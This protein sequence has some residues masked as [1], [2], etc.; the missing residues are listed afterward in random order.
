MRSS[1]STTTT[2][3]WVLDL[4]PEFRFRPSDEK[5]VNLLWKKIN[6]KDYQVMP[7]INYKPWDLPDNESIL[8]FLRFLKQLRQ[9]KASIIP[10]IDFYKHEP[11]DLAGAGLM[12]PDSPYQAR[13]WFCFSRPDYKYVDSPRR[14]RLTE[15]G[16]WKITGQPR[17]VKS[18]QLS[19]SLTCKKK[20]LTFHLGRPKKSSNTGWVKQEYYLTPTDPGSNP[21]QLSG[22][23]LYRV[24][25][26]SADY[27]SDNKKRQDVSICNESLANPAIGGYMASNSQDYHF[28][29]EAEEHVLGTGNLNDGEPGGFVSSDFDDMIQEQ[30]HLDSPSPPP[31]LPRPHQLPQLGNVHGSTGDYIASISDNQVAAIHHMIT[32]EEELLAFKELER[33]LLG[34][35]NPDDGEPGSCVSD[36]LQELCAP[37]G[38]D[39]D[40]PVPPPGPPELGNAPDVYSDECSSWPSQIEDNDSSLPNKNNIPTNYDSKPVSNTASNFENQ[41]KDERIPEVYSQSEENLQWFFRSLEVED[42]TLPSS[43]LYAEQGDGLHANN[44]I[45]CNESQCAALFPQSS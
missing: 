24:K 32:E 40:S 6:G 25:Y 38:E 36:V 20:T 31:E 33:V 13:T 15:K 39:L 10:E 22:L 34:S 26:K 2:E 3:A 12:F 23:V 37:L 14:S 28:I 7:E 19:N 44:F 42:Y 41:T 9:G 45:G 4:L 17:E 16:F 29:P 1:S 11:W 5:M 8:L 30:E 27:E 18:R 21:N 35:G 43:I